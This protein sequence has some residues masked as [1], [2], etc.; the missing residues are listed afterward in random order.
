[1]KHVV[2]LR[3]LNSFIENN[4]ITQQGNIGHS[5]IEWGK[6]VRHHSYNLNDK[7]ISELSNRRVSRSDIFNMIDN[8]SINLLSCIVTILAWGWMKRGHGLSFFKNESHWLP[9][10]QKLRLGQINRKDAYQQFKEIRANGYLNGM[11]PA[12]YTKLIFFL[13]PFHDGYIMDQW[14]GSSI[15]L[16]FPPKVVSLS[17][18]FHVNDH[19]TAD[20]YEDYCKCIESLSHTLIKKPEIVE[21]ML[22]S[23]GGRNK[24]KWRKYVIENRS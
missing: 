22:F 4:D 21:Q 16:L 1:M 8:K 23:Y 12:Y 2:D 20:D 6:W 7:I 5:P 14:T 10:C 11:G 19:N 13:H 15:N 17:S 24:G 3:V 18:Q 9:L